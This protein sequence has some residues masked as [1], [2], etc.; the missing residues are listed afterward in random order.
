[1]EKFIL[2]KDVKVWG[3]PVKNFPEGIGE[4]FDQLVQ[5]LPGGFD[6]SF[7][8]ISQMS[9]DG[10]CIYMAAAEE[11]FEG[12][13]SKYNCESYIIESGEYFSLTVNDWRK[14]TDSIKDA[15]H[16]LMMSSRVNKTKPC[17][18]WYKNDEVMMCMVKVA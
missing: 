4:A 18:E 15:F 14:Q 5:L 12:E 9:G 17:V 1:M 6:R 8:G 16:K 11:V 7:Y 10:K 2:K 3:I 13:G